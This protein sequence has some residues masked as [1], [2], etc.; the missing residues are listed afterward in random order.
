M[1]TH[2]NN[3]K[4]PAFTKELKELL[5]AFRV[6]SLSGRLPTQA[7][8][9]GICRR[10]RSGSIR[11]R[12]HLSKVINGN[13]N[14]FYLK[15]GVNQQ[16]RRCN[17]INLKPEGY[18]LLDMLEANNEVIHPV[19]LERRQRHPGAPTQYILES[20]YTDTAGCKRPLTMLFQGKLLFLEHGV[21]AVNPA[22]GTEVI[23]E[24]KCMWK[25]C[26]DEVLN[27][28]DPQPVATLPHI[29]HLVRHVVSRF[30]V[31]D[32]LYASDFQLEYACLLQMKKLFP[33]TKETEIQV[34]YDRVHILRV[35][36]TKREEVY[37]CSKCK[38]TSCYHLNR[39]HH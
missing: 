2:S 32:S 23:G 19:S 7:T 29:K 33:G 10:S 37:I 31:G 34:G 17:I 22:Y 3:G 28:Q 6:A 16:G 18:R 15:Q 35:P 13:P 11:R 20:Y 36:I 9:L 1:N 30:R 12:K 5:D 21:R 25:Q 39:I 38:E 14:L 27:F 4:V 24:I 8:I 26:R